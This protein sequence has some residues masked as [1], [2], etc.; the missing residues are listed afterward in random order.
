MGQNLMGVV[1]NQRDYA[2][3]ALKCH[4]HEATLKGAQAI[5]ASGSSGIIQAL[6][7]FDCK[8]C[9]ERRMDESALAGLLRSMSK[10]P[11]SQMIGPTKGAQTIS[12]F[13]TPQVPG[14]HTQPKTNISRDE[15]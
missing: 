1:N 9:A 10:N 2:E 15:L 8:N 5:K 7:P 14:G 6:K 3:L 11:E 13:A 12:F 4:V